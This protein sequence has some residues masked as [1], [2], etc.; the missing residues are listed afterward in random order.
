MNN[1]QRAYMFASATVLMWSTVATVF[2]LTLRS[3]GIYPMLL[4]AALT[5]T[6]FLLAALA[7]QGRLG[8][9]G[10]I[11]GRDWLRAATLGFLNPFL[12][13]AVVL[14]SYEL[15]PAQEAQPLNQTWTI[16]IVI[17]SVPLLGQRLR[18]ASLGAI[19]VSYLGV[20]IIATHGQ[21]HQVRL[22]DPFGVFLALASTVVWALYWIYNV[23]DTRDELIK[24]AANFICGTGYCLAAVLL[25]PQTVN[26]SW[27]GWAGAIYLG[28]FEMGVAYVC[29]MKALQLSEN[30][31]RVSNLILLCPFISLALIHFVV[32]EP[33]LG[34]T[35]VGL[36]FIM[37]G[38]VWQ[39]SLA[40]AQAV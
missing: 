11:S 9:L 32:G 12:Y 26:G 29:W 30:T 31:A 16:A 10:R 40:T 1:Q 14:K 36:V 38:V 35:L 8:E 2:K 37:A 24:L 5:S 13:Y 3:L 20:T 22:S 28:L 18:W 34:S 27:T 17:L 21:W 4:G 6:V 39:R 25:F 7:F 19:L 23:K 15:L 33:I